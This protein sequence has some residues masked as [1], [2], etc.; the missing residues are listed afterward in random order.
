M[1]LRKPHQCPVVLSRNGG[2]A[3]LIEVFS[4]ANH[5]SRFGIINAL[6]GIR[7]RFLLVAAF[8]YLV[9]ANLIW[10]SRDSRP[11]YWDMADKQTGALRI[12]DAVA[13]SGARAVAQIPFLT[14]SYPPLYYSIIAISYGLFGKTIDAAQWAN[15]PA[16]AILLIATYG[17]GRTLLKPLPAATAA[18][19]VNFYP[20]LLWLS[21]ETLIDYWL[22]SLVA[23]AIWLLILTKE[24]TNRKF[25]VL[26]GVVCGLGMLTKW[27]FVLFVLLPALWA[28]RKNFKNAAT[29]AL[30]AIG[31]A[32]YWY[33]FAAQALLRLLSIN[34]A[35]SLSEGDPGRFTI[36][37][38][39]FYVRALEGSQLF[40]PLFVL[41]A[42]GAIALLF[43][44]NRS[45]IPIALW[46]AG[47]W[48]GLMLFQNKDPRYTA[49]LLPA[50]ALISAQV[51][52]KKESL[53]ALLL[54]VLLIQHYLV[55]FGIS[56]L[57]AAVVLAKGGN[58]PISYDWNLYTQRYFGWGPP[59][60]EDWKIEYVLSRVAPQDGRTVQLGMVP[61]IP[62]FDTLAFE[63]YIT[64]KK[65]PVSVNRLAV[66]DPRAITS[67][68]YILVSEKDGG[69]EPGSGFTS[70]LKQI[71][72]YI[73][74][75]T[76]IFHRL[77][78]FSLPNGDLIFLY[79]VGSA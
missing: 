29:A 6:M 9:A 59:A 32:A 67:N 75:Q 70:D 62:R 16:I 46:M 45:W 47:G 30:I 13:N 41:F 61:D 8:S 58:G 49:P 18:V 4:R 54:P 21:R 26:F 77:E 68:D 38:A 60:R 12:Y 55:S 28:A 20:L 53:V 51:F 43:N 11:P 66:F 74:E 50:I 24:F 52:Q 14:G 22:T 44:F 35:Q 34:T 10:I 39:T 33:A 42:A 69:F 72:H 73:E 31:I 37:A 3:R 56:A 2:D 23:F 78:S 1:L 76:D 7:H 19:I 79:K 17:I 63:Y 25:T 65:F 36:G 57:P 40:L 64:L 15:L 48:L 27:T 5:S 71:H